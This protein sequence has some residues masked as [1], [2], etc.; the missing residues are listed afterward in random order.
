MNSSEQIKPTADQIKKI[1]DLPI[2]ALPAYT[3]IAGSN[4]VA[5]T[6]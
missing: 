2:L 6:D 1:M 5:T 4:S 3:T